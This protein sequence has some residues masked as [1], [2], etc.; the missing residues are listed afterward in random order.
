MNYPE[1]VYKGWHTTLLGYATMIIPI[2]FNIA[3]RRTLRPI[4][5]VG[6]VLHTVFFV[7]FVA[8]L[9]SLGGRNSASYVFTADSG[10]VSGWT[11]P[12]TQW[13]IGLLSAV[14]PLTG[15]YLLV[16]CNACADF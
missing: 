15:A 3:A 13:C 4:E 9:I 1:Y 5:I 12:G 6:A 8:V 16:K 11:S 14:F 7:A 10:G 2:A